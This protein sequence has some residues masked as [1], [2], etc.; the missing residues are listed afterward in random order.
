MSIILHTIIETKQSMSDPTLVP[1]EPTSTLVHVRPEL[2]S[3]GYVY[4]A[5]DQR[6][7]FLFL[8]QKLAHVQ[9]AIA[10][11]AFEEVAIA[12]LYEAA[13]RCRRTAKAGSFRVE[14]MSRAEAPDWLSQHRKAYARVY[15]AAGNPRRWEI[16]NAECVGAEPAEQ[17]DV[18]VEPGVKPG[19]RE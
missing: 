19:S 10:D 1:I 3:R 13:N 16:A 17:V 11:L 14:R 15:I 12:T 8:A 9:S 7:T 6:R 4:A 18:K 5:T 2:F